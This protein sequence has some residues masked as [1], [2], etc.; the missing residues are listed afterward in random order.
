MSNPHRKCTRGLASDHSIDG[1]RGRRSASADCGSQ[2]LKVR[3]WSIAR[4]FRATIVRIV[5]SGLI[6]AA[7]M[8]HA[9]A[10]TPVADLGCRDAVDWVA[11]D[12]QARAVPTPSKPGQAQVTGRDGRVYTGGEYRHIETEI[13]SAA[14]D[15]EAGRVSDSLARARDAAA[16]INPTGQVFARTADKTKVP[17]MSQAD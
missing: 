5:I 9:A 10:Q 1:G 14:L 12:W 2:Q 15:C 8:A 11:R 17:P 4:P 3:D 6:T 16:L 13:R 7:A